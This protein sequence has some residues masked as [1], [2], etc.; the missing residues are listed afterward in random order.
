MREKARVL[1]CVKTAYSY[2][3]PHRWYMMCQEDYMLRRFIRLIG[4]SL[5]LVGCEPMSNTNPATTSTVPPGSG[6]AISTDHTTYTPSDTIAVTVHN[7]L[8]TPIYAMDTMSSCSILSLQYQVNGAWQPSQVA[9]CPMGRPARLVKIEAGG[10]YTAS[11]TAGYPGW[12]QLTFPTGRYRLVLLYTA[13]PSVIPT[14][15]SGVMVT[16]PTIQVR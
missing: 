6:V 8:S 15:D 11:I 10:N 1:C 3:M 13:S 2:K 9:H 16:S 5:L 14:A 7:L 4:L 12:S